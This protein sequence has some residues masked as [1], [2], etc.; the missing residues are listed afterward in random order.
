MRKRISEEFGMGQILINSIASICILIRDKMHKSIITTNIEIELPT[1]DDN[2]QY[3]RV[4]IRIDCI[5]IFLSECIDS[6]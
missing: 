3:N 5:C 1:F 4:I 6:C 2:L